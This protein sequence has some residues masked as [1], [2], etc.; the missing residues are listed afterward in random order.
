MPL[1]LQKL[2]LYLVFATLVLVLA[3]RFTITHLNSIGLLQVDLFLPQSAALD[4][5]HHVALPLG[6]ELVELPRG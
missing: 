4:L 1:P 3:L 5:G 6:L 2:I